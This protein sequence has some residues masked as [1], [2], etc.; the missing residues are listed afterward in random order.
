MNIQNIFVTATLMFLFAC[1]SK[2]EPSYPDTFAPKVVEARGYVVPKDQISPPKVIPAGKPKVVHAGTPKVIPASSNVYP[3][4]IPKVVVAGVPRV[5]TPGKD[6]FS[7][8]PIVP[9]IDSPFIAGIPEVVIAKEAQTKEQNPHSFS[10][11]SKLQGLKHNEI[12]CLLQDKIGNLWIGTNG[13][14]VSKYDGKNFTH[15][16]IKEGL[17]W[18]FIWSILEDKKGNIWFATQGGGVSKYDGKNFTHYNI[19]N[20][21]NNNNVR[22]IME[23]KSGNIWFGTVGGGVNKYDGKSFTHFTEKEGLSSNM[24]HSILEDKKGNLWFGTSGGVT[25][26]NGQ[27]FIHFTEKEGLS[28]NSVFSILEDKSGNLWFGTDGGVNKFDGQSFTHFTEKEGLSNEYVKSILEDNNGNLWFCTEGGGVSKFNG[29]SFIHFTEK[30]GLSQNNVWSILEDKNGHL[31]FGTVGG[32]TKYNGQIFSHFTDMDGLDY[33]D[34]WSILEDKNANLWFST[35]HRGVAKFDGKNFVHFTKDQ[36]LINNVVWSMLQDKWGDLWFGTFSGVSKYDGRTFTHFTEKEGLGNNDVKSMLEDKNGNLWFG[37]VGGVSKYDGINFTRFTEKEGLSHNFFLCL[38]I[39]EDK[40]GNLWFGSA[41]GVTKYDG[42]NFTHFTE[43]EGLSNNFVRSILED[44]SGNLWVGTEGGVSK[45]D[46][47]N[48]TYFTEQ[49]GLI[50]NDVKIISEDKNGNLWFGTPFGLSKLDRN[51]ISIVNHKEAGI[52]FKNYTYEDGFLG[53]GVNFG[54]TILQTQDGTIWIGAD[55]MLTAFHPDEETRN[56]TAPNIQITGLTL[57]NE[58]IP[59]QNFISTSDMSLHSNQEEVKDTSLMLGNGVLVHDIYFDSLSRWNGVP[60]HLS[61]PYDNNNITIQ[62][63]GISIQSPKKVKYQYKLEGLDQNWSSLT[64]RSE[65]TYANLPHGKYIFKVKAMNGEGLWSNELSYS[66]L[67]RPP[68]WHTWW[69]YSLYGVLIICFLF[70]LRQYTVNRE[71][72][73]HELKIQKLESEKMHEIDHLKSRFFA[74]ISHEFRTPLTLILGHLDKF[75]TRSPKDHPDQ[76]A[77]QMMHRNARRLQQ[78]INHLLD[79]SKLEAGSMKLDLKPADLIAFLKAMI[80]SFTSHA[81]TK[82]IQYHF[83]YPH[84][85]P[86]VY[87]D[88]DKLEKII[89]NLLSNAF[90]FTKPEGKIT[91]TALIETADKKS[92]PDFFSSTAPTSTARILELS[93]EDSGVGIPRDQLD[94]IFD[95]FYQADT[96]HTRE[97]EGTGIGLSLVRELVELYSGEIKVESQPGHG[98]CFTVRLPVLLADYEEVTITGTAFNDD[99]KSVIPIIDN[100]ELIASPDLATANDDPEA[101]LVLIIEDNEDVRLFIKE[102]LQP[103]YQVLE[104]GDGE[105]GYKLAVKTIP[106]LILS[107]VMMP[108]MDGV[109]LC[110]KLKGNV[111]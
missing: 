78:L 85:H 11:F 9:A 42:K 60:E 80:F 41:G 103:F 106:D 75:L 99:K 1:N 30:E 34:V 18:N 63:V 72:M 91:I 39:L 110:R 23:D 26:Y 52:L 82:K 107:D 96:S 105:E 40:S 109:E 93:V 31:W 100:G 88:A 62:Y 35:R 74:N 13:G 68:W 4:G 55:E 20:G 5:C 27:S 84:E 51:K 24:I 83:K 98:S 77:Y 29:Q 90:K 46:G 73:M 92:L 108:K 50:N 67:V 43:K 6:G 94:R 81:E 56:T 97:Q 79:L 54:K 66:F 25:K 15:F 111:N 44:K 33:I 47:K 10:F 95:R 28:S 102:T 59:W 48:F 14:G 101:P 71:R 2:K 3:A 8:P 104:A 57:F 58:N 53:I 22:C 87:F 38:S 7:L 65:A 21:L 12:Y 45:Y 17:S 61:L 49:E 19:K 16:T 32:L 89:T 36:G 70:G 64:N 69:A 76:P 86:V 37:T